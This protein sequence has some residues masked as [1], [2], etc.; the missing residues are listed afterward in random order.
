MCNYRRVVACGVLSSLAGFRSKRLVLMMQGCIHVLPG[1]PSVKRL[2]PQDYR[3]YTE[4]CLMH[5]H[6]KTLA[7]HVKGQPA[8]TADN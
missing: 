2:P 1:T 4:V 3:L 7:N 5:T 6:T 8:E